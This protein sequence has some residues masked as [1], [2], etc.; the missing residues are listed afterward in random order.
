MK[1]I[2][3]TPATLRPKIVRKTFA[4]FGENLFNPAVEAGIDLKLALNIDCIGDSEFSSLDIIWITGAYIECSY[5]NI[6][7]RGPFS[8]ASAFKRLW[9][10][11]A[12]SNA[13]YSFYLEDDWILHQK[14]DVLKMIDCFESHKNLATLRLPFKKT[15]AEFSK[16]W[17]HFFPWNG[18]FF[19]CPQEIKM[20]IGWC[21]HPNMVSVEYIREMLPH[22]RDDWCPE[23]QMKGKWGMEKL[24]KKWDF[25]VYGAPNEDRYIEDIG[26]VWRAE[27]EIAKLSNTTWNYGG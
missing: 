20:S 17:S 9:K 11:V 2:V 19:E 1:I 15:D 23:L 10:Y 14:V 3:T 4:S 6:N 26:R 21:G 8:L 16:N 27:R 18:K 5:L 7:A 22:L 25:G 13:D 12:E 24:L